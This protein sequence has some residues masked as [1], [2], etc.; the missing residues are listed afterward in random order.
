MQAHNK[1]VITHKLSIK[2]LFINSHTTKAAIFNI[3]TA[4]SSPDI[5]QQY[6]RRRH[7]HTILPPDKET[8]CVYRHYGKMI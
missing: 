8:I 6:I 7:R 3:Q 5:C 2:E 4:L 1:V